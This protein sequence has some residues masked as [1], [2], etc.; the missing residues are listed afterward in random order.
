MR[1]TEAV[2]LVALSL[3]LCVTGLVWL[4]GPYGLIGS[5]IAL[6]AVALFVFDV[7]ESP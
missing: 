7:K 1:R 3:G 4:F 6:A 2:I 5:G